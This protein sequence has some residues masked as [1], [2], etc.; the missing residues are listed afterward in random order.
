VALSLS[1]GW[2]DRI[3]TA[4]LGLML[5][6]ELVRIAVIE[7][8]VS[9]PDLFRGPMWASRAA[10]VQNDATNASSD[11]WPAPYQFSDGAAF[12]RTS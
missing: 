1:S 6:A 3:P 8:V 4:L 7:P 11:P 12:R 10:Q 5:T 2:R 9:H